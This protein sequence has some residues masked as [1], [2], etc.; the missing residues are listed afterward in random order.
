MKSKQIS[1]CAL[2]AALSCVIMLTAWF[3]YI[4]YAVPCFASLTIMV[5]MIEYDKRSAIMTYLVSLLPIML[6]CEAES[7]LLYL[8]FM[9]F[10]PILKALIEKMKF[11]FTEYII[12][13]ICFNS[14]I[15]ILYYISSFVFGVSYDDLGELGKYGTVVF[16]V[17]VNLDFIVYD[18]CI[19]K[20]AEFY[21]LRFH[22][23]VDK[24]LKK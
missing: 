13:F 22:K 17:L 5:V 1:F 14:G 11:R 4:T 10:Y 23:R 3:P 24:M 16:L 20:M 18:F 8:C 2:M 6:F 7:K 15:V 12:K 21:L 9:G 19:T